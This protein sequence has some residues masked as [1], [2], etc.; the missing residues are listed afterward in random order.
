MNRITMAILMT[1][2]TLSSAYAQTQSTGSPTDQA[3]V[4]ASDLR[5]AQLMMGEL[6]EQLQIAHAKM[7]SD[8]IDRKRSVG[9][10][11]ALSTVADE[12][13]RLLAAL[14]QQA[15]ERHQRLCDH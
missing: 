9:R 1:T 3:H 6:D 13:Q 10:K 15:S 5:Y 2:T 7:G 4:S 14:T 8:A 12:Q 11:K